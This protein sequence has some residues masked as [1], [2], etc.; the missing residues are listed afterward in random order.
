M[1]ELVSSK[2][3]KKILPNINSLL[4]KVKRIYNVLDF[5]TTN[6]I[7]SITKS[8]LFLDKLLDY[9][10]DEILQIAENEYNIRKLLLIIKENLVKL[11]EY[12]THINNNLPYS[13]INET[14]KDL[15][16]FVEM[17]HITNYKLDE[18]NKN[19][20]E[21]VVNTLYGMFTVENIEERFLEMSILFKK[22]NLW[23]LYNIVTNKVIEN[24][25]EN[26]DIYKVLKLNELNKNFVL[27]ENNSNYIKS[28]GLIPVSNVMNINQISK[29][30]YLKDA[31]NVEEMIKLCK[32]DSDLIIIK[33]Y[34]GR[35]I[36]YNVLDL[37]NFE[38]SKDYSLQNSSNDGITVDSIKRFDS[39]NYIDKNIDVEFS[40]K[41]YSNS[42]KVII[43][44]EL[45]P[46]NYHIL[47]NRF[48]FDDFTIKK[49]EISEFLNRGK[50]L[51]RIDN[52]NKMI[53][54]KILT[55]L[56]AS[57]IPDM[58]QIKKK[59]FVDISDLR[60][61]LNLE[62][63][64]EYKAHKSI[65]NLY[66]FGKCIHDKKFVNIFSSIIKEKYNVK[67]VEIFLSYI[68]R[69]NIIERDFKKQL[70]DNF[71]KSVD[72]LKEVFDSNSDIDFKL[73]SIFKKIIN[74][75]INFIIL[76]NN[77]YTYFDFRANF[78]NSLY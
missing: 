30:I 72:Q 61:S 64:N 70:H 28:Y 13:Y 21:K 25:K 35:G 14:K 51:N 24:F 78:L 44:E 49:D 22:Y 5:T 7:Q 23:H 59:S 71:I 33:K 75:V 65:K 66:E 38:K 57:N 67:S 73:F 74:N 39:I 27:G 60:Y 32:P 26:P 18:I 16:N 8:L 29:L 15:L 56:F 43:L 45:Y 34:L 3:V 1:S 46:N 31:A 41:H 19:L 47:S 77:P 50:N 37:V 6:L 62:I 4:E 20:N 2:T 40:Y 52:Y 9:K 69:L 53:N 11:L 12:D 10:S 58:R 63:S 42:N 55:N 68:Y 76:D 54:K 48:D 17:F 36:K